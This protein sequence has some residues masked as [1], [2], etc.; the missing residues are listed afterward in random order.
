MSISGVFQFILGFF[1]GICI[2][3]GSAVGVAYYLF[4]QM[5]AVPSKPIFPEE[6]TREISTQKTIEIDKKTDSL[7]NKSK[8]ESDGY[9]ARVTWP[10]GLILRAQPT[11][12]SDRLGAI[13]YK[14][15]IIVIQDSQ[16]L[17]WQKIRELQTNREGWI[18]SGN[19]EKINP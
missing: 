8:I 15:E 6:K 19:I 16:D 1:L 9:R 14:S 5:T 17:E 11:S 18:K 13:G 4:T 7:F 2:L 12:Q 3:S 10:Q